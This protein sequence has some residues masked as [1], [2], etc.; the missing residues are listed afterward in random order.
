MDSFRFEK[1]DGSES[2]VRAG[3]SLPLR[4]SPPPLSGLSARDIATT[5]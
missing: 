3:E 4:L 2:L 1:L 5:S